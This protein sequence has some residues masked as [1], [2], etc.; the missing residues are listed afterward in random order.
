[1]DNQNKKFLDIDNLISEVHLITQAPKP[2]I[3]SSFLSV[4]SSA[5]QGLLDIEIRD[6][7]IVPCNLFLLTIADSGERKSTVER[8]LYKPISV[9]NDLIMIKNE[10]I[11][12]QY[13]SEMIRWKFQ[14]DILLSKQK[15]KLYE[16]SNDQI[17]DALQHE[18][19]SLYMLR[20][21]MRELTHLLYSD[22]TLESLLFNL[23]KQNPYS[24]LSSSDA[25]NILNKMNYNYLCNINKIWDGDSIQVDRKTKE[26]FLVKD[27]R[28]TL[29]LMVQPSVFKSILNKNEMLRQTGALSRILITQCYSTQGQRFYSESCGTNYLDEFYH[30]IESICN[31]SLMMSFSG[32]DKIHMK[33]TPEAKEAWVLFYNQIESELCYAALQDISDFASKIANNVVRVAALLHY[34]QY[35]TEFICKDCMLDAIKFGEESL[36]SFKRLFGEK[37]VEEQAKEY[38]GILFSWLYKNYRSGV[39]DILKRHIY[40]FG[41]N[42]LRNKHNLEMALWYMH[43]C[44]DIIYYSN[45]KPAYIS[46]TQNF[47][48]T[49]VQ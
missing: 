10:S 46:L 19:D 1:M 2:I 22:I 40:H 15:K 48:N 44:G 39:Y 4:L 38:A 12:E 23:S 32:V 37:T 41:P 30:R 9:I 18:L 36:I 5:S 42:L 27:A 20:P 47:F 16:D 35:D 33:M 43:N 34:Y 24:T 13:Q 17:V 49:L 11:K 25:G 26:S 21:K 3:Y 31:R 29:S 6:G 28:L 7:M 14:L 8:L 45:A